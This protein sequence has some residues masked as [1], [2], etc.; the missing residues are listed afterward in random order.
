MLDEI[1]GPLKSGTDIR[2]TAVAGVPGEDVNLTDEALTAISYGFAAWLYE[3]V[4]P[5]S[6]ELFTVA[7]GHDSRVSAERIKAAVLPPLLDCG[8]NIK[9][10]GLCSTPAM[11]MTTVDFGCDASIEITASHHPWNK[12]GLKFFIRKGGLEGY[13]IEA[14][15]TNAQYD[16][17]PELPDNMPKGVVEEVNYMTNYAQQLREKICADVNAD[18]YSRPLRGFHIVVDAGNGVGGFYAEKVL[19]PL[20]ADVEGSQFLE[21]DGMFPNH[22]PNPEN[23]DAMAAISKAVLDNNADLGVI[24]DTDVDRAACVASDGK[25]INRNALIALASVIALEGNEGGTI[26]TDSVTSS[27]L[28]T[29]IE[30][31][32]GGKHHR[33]K[34]GYKNVINESKRLN[35]EECVNSPLAIETSGHAAM[36]ENY[37][38]DDG[39]YLMTKIIIKAAQM[40][41]EGLTLDSLI[42]DLKEPVEAEE[43]RVKILDP[44]FKTYGNMVLEEFEKWLRENEEYVVANDSFEG[45][46]ATKTAV[47]GWM[48]L[49]L[50]VHDPILPLNI[51]T[52][53]MG[54]AKN[55][56]ID[57]KG[58]LAGFDKLDISAL[59]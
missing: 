32:L 42:K 49:R 6:G 4:V 37:F 29:F 40:Q 54:G 56:L 35:M 14:I 10:C 20:G 55:I 5:Q 38:L 15:L 59:G 50:S 25:E 58:F 12:N 36:R 47:D 18:D 11:F 1:Y 26:V 43:Y 3:N 17:R 30:E 21:P 57:A 2:G 31:T 44:D 27:G 39:A 46:R 8:I 9:D 28:K 23:K 19:A 52:N 7:I 53:A 51:E 16:V 33:F 48:L 34:R 22:I 13:D 41:K 45:V 24:F